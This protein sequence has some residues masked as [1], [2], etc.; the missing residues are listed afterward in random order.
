[1]FDRQTITVRCEP[2]ADGWRCAVAVGSDSGA[3][4]HDVIVHR[5][6]LRRIAPPGSPVESFVEASFGFLLEREPRESILRRFDLPAI[7]RFF[8]EYEDVI[9]ARLAGV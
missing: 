1:M 8:P 6:Y 5:D 2:D 4:Q 9:R 3:T 7:G